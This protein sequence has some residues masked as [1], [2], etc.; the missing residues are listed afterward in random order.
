MSWPAF[1]SAVE[2]EFG[3]EEFEAQMNQLVQLHHTGSV[4]E[5][6]QQ[7]ETSMYHLW[8][9]DPTLSTQFFI[10][11]F[12]LGLKVELRLGVCLHAPTSITQAAV[13]ARIQEEELEKQR[14]PRNCI[15]PVG[16]PPPSATTSTQT[17]IVSQPRLGR[18]DYARERQL[19]EFRRANGLCFRCG[20]KYSRNH[21]CKRTGQ[22]LMIEVGDFGE[23]HSHDTVH[24]LQLLDPP[25][26]HEPE[27]CA[28]SQ[29]PV[30]R[31]EAPSTIRLRAQVGDQYMLLLVDSG[32]SHSFLSDSF[33]KSVSPNRGI[34]PGVSP[35][36][37]RSVSALQQDC[38]KFGVAS[39]WT[40]DSH[41]PHTPTIQ[42]I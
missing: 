8:S 31:D 2:A 5:Y 30:S 16:R 27:C 36:G 23:I 17:C 34:A 19:K 14:A 22:I 38:A 11:Q 21:Q 25:G 35:G 32:S 24:A 20:N 7:F 37:Q 18:D 40:H 3:L 41:R 15:V 42:G 26:A 9:L 33:T 28:T 12:L 6:C 13:F 29:H 39:T 1:R 10:S 4:Q